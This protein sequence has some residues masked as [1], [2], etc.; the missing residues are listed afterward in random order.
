MPSAH[1]LCPGAPVIA[2]PATGAF[3]AGK[4]PETLRG[5]PSFV[6]AKLGKP[7]PSRPPTASPASVAVNKGES[8][9]ISPRES[10]PLDDAQDP[11]TPRD[12]PEPADPS[13]AK[14]LSAEFL[15]QPTLRFSPSSFPAVATP[16]QTVA[17]STK[18]SKVDSSTPPE[19]SPSPSP[20]GGPTS[21]RGKEGEE[22]DR[23]WWRL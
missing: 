10:P 20:S 11:Y 18:R 16:P 15:S 5:S 2:T 8:Q 17:S 21:G 9:Y 4:H 7:A 22:K 3:A 6:D 13:I 19:P 1:L 23:L 12:S 14:S